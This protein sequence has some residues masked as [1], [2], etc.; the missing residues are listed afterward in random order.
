M[1]VLFSLVLLFYY[2]YSFLLTFH[3]QNVVINLNSS[4][5]DCTVAISLLCFLQ[6]NDQ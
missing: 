2:C 3:I 6:T 4:N 1:D 5:L